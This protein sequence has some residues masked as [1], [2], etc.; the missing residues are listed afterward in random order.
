MR[1]PIAF[2]LALAAAGASLGAAPAKRPVPKPAKRPPARVALVSPNGLALDVAGNLFITDIATHRLLKFAPHGAL[3]VVAGTGAGGFSGDGLPASRARLFAPHAAA[4]DAAGNLLVADTYN[5]RIRRI[6]REGI[7]TTV[8]GSGRG[9]YTGDNGLALKASLN[10]PQGIAPGPDGSLYIA[11][12]YNHVVRRVDPKGTITTFAGTEAGL[13][14]DGGPANRAQISLPTDVAV[15]PD[16]TVF[17]SDSGNNRIRRVDPAG[18][19]DTVL[20]T[21]PGSGTAGAG[22]GGDGGPA[23]NAR[24][25]AAAGLACG[26]AGDLFIA[27]TG[28]HRVRL[29]SK[30]V[31]TTIAGSGTAGFSGDGGSAPAAA[32]NS[33]QKLVL[34][35]DGSLYIADRANHCVRRVDASGRIESVGRRD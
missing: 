27:D 14:G 20:G 25:F 18:I 12:T 17:I 35:K 11:D 23:R 30:G 29:I 31:I 26:P 1:V 9:A 16:G 24:I 22:F 15:G 8:A 28:N 5:H 13:A 2:A 7:I 6:D 32:L 4:V 10:N 19:I 33:P 21:G 3:T 34:G